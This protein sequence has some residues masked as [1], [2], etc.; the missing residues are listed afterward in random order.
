[1]MLSSTWFEGSAREISNRHCERER[2][3][4]DFVGRFIEEGRL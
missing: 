2:C 4:L 3:Y 1:M